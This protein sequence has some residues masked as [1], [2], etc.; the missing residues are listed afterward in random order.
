MEFKGK[1][2]EKQ[3]IDFKLIRECLVDYARDLG[4]PEFEVCVVRRVVNAFMIGKDDPLKPAV[5]RILEIKIRNSKMNSKRKIVADFCNRI[6][7]TEI[8]M[9]HSKIARVTFN[10]FINGSMNLT[11]E[12][13]ARVLDAFDIA[14]E[15]YQNHMKGSL[16]YMNKKLKSC[17]VV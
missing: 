11:D 9:K 17:G 16:K 3:E 8:L 7:A 2:V 6:G 1:D 5:E 14:E 4:R 12:Q 10:R 15:E 13:W